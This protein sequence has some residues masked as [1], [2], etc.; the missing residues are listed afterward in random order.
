MT[1]R[2]SSTSLSGLCG[3]GHRSSLRSLLAGICG[4]GTSP[5]K[6]HAYDSA[7][8]PAAVKKRISTPLGGDG[9]LRPAWPVESSFVGVGVRE[10][11]WR[12]WDTWGCSGFCSRGMACLLHSACI[13]CPGPS[14][15]AYRRDLLARRPVEAVVGPDAEGDRRARESSALGC[16]VAKLPKRTRGRYP[17]WV[18]RAQQRPVREV[19]PRL[20]GA[21]RVG[22]SAD[23]TPV[24]S[25]R[26]P[27]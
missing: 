9:G 3:D 25:R 17:R 24:S 2:G 13:A 7:R 19:V 23:V 8:S 16:E 22:S 26:S 11:G 10:W 6:A 15:F 5:P 12:C 14:C 20:S 21:T 18:G 1:A 4:S 27:R